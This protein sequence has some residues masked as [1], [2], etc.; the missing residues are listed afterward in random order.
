MPFYLYSLSNSPGFLIGIIMLPVNNLEPA[1]NT[2]LSAIPKETPITIL[3]AGA[4]AG[5]SRPPIV[6]MSII[7]KPTNIPANYANI[8]HELLI[9]LFKQF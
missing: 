5:D 4:F 8:L 2:K 3:A 6:N 7:P 1:A 9:L